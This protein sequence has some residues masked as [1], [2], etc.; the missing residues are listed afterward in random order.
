MDDILIEPDFL[1]HIIRGLV[2][3]RKCPECDI[4]GIELQW[5]DDD[6]NAVKAG[7]DGSRSTC[8]CESCKGVGFIQ[9]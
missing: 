1:N 5:Y 3:F 4:D 9:C 2:Q 6:G 7:S 8:M